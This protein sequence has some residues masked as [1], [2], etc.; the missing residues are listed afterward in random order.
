MHRSTHSMTASARVR[1]H[2]TSRPT[3]GAIDS[4]SA[5][6]P[7]P[8]AAAGSRRT[9]SRYA[10]SDLF[11]QLQPFPLKLYSN[12]IEPVALPQRGH[13]PGRGFV[14]LPARA[15]LHLRWFDRAQL[16]VSSSSGNCARVHEPH[17]I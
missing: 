9:R 17:A 6:W 1:S 16:G 5:N 14:P 10:L 8:D 12:I 3:D 7:I 4:I 13:S 2:I 11:E 15:Y